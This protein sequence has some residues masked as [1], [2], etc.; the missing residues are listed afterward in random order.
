MKTDS[1]FYSLF[2]T[3]PSIFFELINKSPAEAVGYEFTSCEVKQLAFRLDGLF[4][5][6]SNPEKPFYVVEVQFQADEDL[7]Y[8][9]F[10]ELFLYL[11]QYKPV[12]PWQVVVIYPTRSIERQQTSQ[13]SEML[14]INRVRRIYLDE[15]GEVAETSL[16]VGVV[17]LVIEAEETA[18]QLARRLIDQAKQQLTDEVGKRDLI[19]LIETIIVYKLP[20]KSREEIEAMLGL[21]ELKQTKVYQEALE[22]GKQQGLE[23]GLTQGK[24]QN[25]LETIPRMV[26]FGLSEDAIA[27][28]LDLPLEVVQQAVQQTDG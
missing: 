10:A 28:L 1:I 2:Q 18:P 20:Q 21:S 13:F 19:N 15:L 3:F 9:L 8:R 6:T 11:R 24:Q 25:K 26:E 12:S 5:P 17:K 16:G 14:A 27:Q 7:Y 4:L 23:E 22:E